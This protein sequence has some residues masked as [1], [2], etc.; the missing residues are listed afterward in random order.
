MITEKCFLIGKVLR[1]LC[2]CLGIPLR[3]TQEQTR[4]SRETMQDLI[5]ANTGCT[6]YQYTVV[7]GYSLKRGLVAKQ[8]FSFVIGFGDKFESLVIVPMNCKSSALTGSFLR[9]DKS[10]LKVVQAT[11]KRREKIMISPLLGSNLRIII[12][13]Y[14]CH[15]PVTRDGI[16]PIVQ[17]K[18]AL[19][20]DR[21]LQ[22]HYNFIPYNKLVR[23]KWL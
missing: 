7:Y 14:T 10:V 4:A 8:V 19:A 12:P 6:R 11:C 15:D 22:L 23:R 5:V 16:L 20:F 17:K 9:L 18:E 13:Y 3:A 1:P 2:T 21:V